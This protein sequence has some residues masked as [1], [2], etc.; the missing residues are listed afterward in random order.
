MINTHWKKKIKQFSIW[1]DFTLLTI[2]LK[3]IIW[4]SPS[5]IIKQKL[6]VSCSQQ[7]WIATASSI[8]KQSTAKQQFFGK[9]Y[10]N[11]CS[12]CDI[13]TTAAAELY[14]FGLL[15]W[16]MYRY[17]GP[18]TIRFQTTT[19]ECCFKPKTPITAS[20]SPSMSIRLC[21][22]VC[23]CVCASVCWETHATRF[24]DTTHCRPFI[25][26]LLLSI[27]T[28]QALLQ[29]VR[30]IFL[31]KKHTD[32]EQ[33]IP[34]IATVCGYHDA[35][36]DEIYVENIERK[37]HCKFSPPL[38]RGMDLRYRDYLA[39]TMCVFFLSCNPSAHR[40][41][42]S[43]LMRCNSSLICFVHATKLALSNCRDNNP[44]ILQSIKYNF[45]TLT[46]VFN[47]IFNAATNGRR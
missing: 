3:L 41:T 9:T 31:W 30:H 44:S 10:S 28:A 42:H 37:I 15:I 29:A 36:N 1:L 35:I 6:R 8:L 21:A 4:C 45:N 18:H 7:I 39:C 34:R 24:L 22:C 11:N 46:G 13:H 47:T 32:S 38:L 27:A 19:I 43:S 14:R 33:Y 20:L 26:K 2:Y 17:R 16:S 5:E 40:F 23:V 12:V 25:H